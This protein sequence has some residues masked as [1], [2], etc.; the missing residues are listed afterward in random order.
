MKDN[1]FYVIITKMFPTAEEIIIPIKYISS[2]DFIYKSREAMFLIRACYEQNQINNVYGQN[3]KLEDE[4]KVLYDFVLHCN[5]IIQED[6][7]MDELDAFYEKQ[8][9]LIQQVPFIQEIG[10]TFD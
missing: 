3:E 2:F 7:G 1:N 4:Y 5:N 9:P 8:K 10:T 6:K